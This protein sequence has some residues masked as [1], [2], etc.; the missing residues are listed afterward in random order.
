MKADRFHDEMLDEA[1]LKRLAELA[2]LARGDI[3]KMTT[4][5]GSGHPGAPCRPSISIL[6]STPMLASIPDL[7][8]IPIATASSSAMVIPLRSLCGPRE[9]R[10]LSG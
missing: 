8:P 5:A 6:S 3:L 2:K 7:H 9:N 10:L 4:L 1:S